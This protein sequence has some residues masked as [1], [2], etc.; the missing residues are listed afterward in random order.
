[1]NFYRRVDWGR[2]VWVWCLLLWAVPCFSQSNGLQFSS[3]ESVQDLRTS[4]DLN[5]S[6][7]IGF[8]EDLELTFEL[9]FIPDQ[10]VY[11]GYIVRIAAEGQKNIDLI[12]NDTPAAAAGRFKVIVG[13]KFTD[14][15][16]N[17]SPNSLFDHWNKIKLRIDKKKQELAVEIGGKT[18]KQPYE[19]SS[20]AKYRIL[21]GAN[22]HKEFQ[23]TDVPPMKLRNIDISKSGKR[24]DFLPLDEEDGNVA[25]DVNGLMNGTVTNPVWIKKL[26]RSWHDQYK[27]SVRGLVCSAMD[28]V[29]K[30][31]F[32]IGNDS[33]YTYSLS[34]VSANSIA[35]KSGSL[36]L[37]KGNQAFFD[38]VSKNLFCY[39]I[40]QK[41][42]AR[43]DFA[44]QTW[45]QN[46]IYPIPDYITYYWHA[47]K[48]YSPSD[49]SLYTFGGYGQLAFKNTVHQYSFATK[50]WISMAPDSSVFPPRYL[51]AG[52][53][54]EK[55]IYI[56]GGFGS[57]TGQQILSPRFWY[58]LV[59]FDKTSKKFTKV[60]D[61]KTDLRDFAFAN[62]LV[63]VGNRFYA[64]LFPKN[65]Y[66]SS[67]QL[68]EGSLSQPEIKTLA[69]PIPY[70]FR[71]NKSFSDLFYC[72]KDEQLVA[73][74]LSRTED[75]KTTSIHIYSLNLPVLEGGNEVAASSPSTMGNMWIWLAGTLLAGVAGGWLYIR[76]RRKS[77]AIPAQIVVEPVAPV[78]S[79]LITEK[80]K[81]SVAKLMPGEHRNEISLFGDMQIFDDQGND[82]TASFTPLIR[83]LFLL[84]LLNT[85]RWERGISS[86]KLK[87]TLWF[88]KT[89]E[90]A[91][92][93]RSV[94]LGKLKNI[95]NK[96]KSCQVVQVGSFWKIEFESGLTK[97]DYRDYL[98]I[99]SQ[100]GTA[101]RATIEKLM[102]ITRKGAFLFNLEY[103][104]LDSFKSDISNEIVNMYQD[105]A[106]TVQI[107]DDPDFLINLANHIFYFDPVNEVAVVSKCRALAH[108]GKH[109]LAKATF[110]TFTKEYS[111]IYGETFHKDFAEILHVSS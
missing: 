101:D 23:T 97:I 110:A 7:D 75:D 9:S 74:T 20:T 99:V 48:F 78:K 95:L 64:L 30:T 67:L 81:P 17:I 80:E 62:S 39:S 102:T 45:D 18:F 63:I 107:A 61:L 43:F 52:G 100:K 79:I 85:I 24:I 84:I 89:T 25:K 87:E 77:V 91:R 31:V 28:P 104:W 58:D 106:S 66:N 57:P 13:G 12:Y 60:Y 44:K 90:S 33:L 6:T 94:N 36:N 72:S 70:F 54:N 53:A 47:N 42:I 73:L 50:S 38:T 26:H 15:N 65:T 92:N 11:F 3:Y 93:N 14:L 76:N 98:E 46:F 40:D 71:D 32:V 1:M 8:D 2:F 105:F 41:R 109:S 59:F 96:M 51:A 88:D 5:P 29:S 55:G 21:F 27:L 16:F 69:P 68:I 10:K 108:L 86:E 4:L 35:Y 34:S 82:I 49:S 83:E 22:H 103:E 19:V 111:R 37:S 56:L